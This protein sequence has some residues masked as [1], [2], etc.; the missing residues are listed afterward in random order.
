MKQV[1]ARYIL[2]LTATPYRRDGLQRL[3]HFQCGPIR[4]Q[5]QPSS[6]EGQRPFMNRLVVRE[7]RF[8][9][10][11]SIQDLYA[12]LVGNPL[13][14]ALIIQDVRQALA[15]G[16]SPIVLTERRDHL[17]L[18]MKALKDA[19][20]HV[21]VLHGGVPAK[22]RRKALQQLA[23]VPPSE[24]RLILAT[25][26][27][28]GEGFDDARL[29]TLFLAMPIAWKGTLVQYAGRLHRLHPGKE[30]VRIYDYLDDSLAVFRKMFEKR[31]RGYRAMGYQVDDS[32]MLP[33]L[34][35]IDEG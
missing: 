15:E 18:L 34:S 30:E 33:G 8:F 12:S 24:P 17:D 31:M 5:V 20:G 11:G 16:R 29:D 4:F 19:A 10:Q 23:G 13:R 27:Y 6:Q 22:V 35:G 3:L 26:R 2:G 14:N 7:T 25:G 21:V 28:I 1:K 32:G 9:A